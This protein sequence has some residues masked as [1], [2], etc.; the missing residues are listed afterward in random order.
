M[1]TNNYIHRFL[2]NGHWQQ[3]PLSAVTKIVIHHTAAP[4]DQRSNNDRLQQHAD[5]EVHSNDW[6]GLAYH[7]MIMRDGQVYQLNE[8]SDVSYTNGIN[9]DSLAVCLDGYFHPPVNNQPTS[10]QL[11]S[12]Q[13][14]LDNLCNH[15]PEFPASQGDVVGHRE[16][17]RDPTA[18]PG[19]G[20]I[21]YVIN[22]RQK[23]QLLNRVNNPPIIMSNPPIPQLQ[24]KVHAAINE[25]Q[26]SPRYVKQYNN[27][28]RAHGNTDAAAAGREDLVWIR[29]MSNDMQ[30]QADKLVLDLRTQVQLLE[31]FPIHNQVQLMQWCQEKGI[32]CLIDTKSYTS[33]IDG[34]HRLVALGVI[35]E[36]T[37][38]QLNPEAIEQLK[39]AYT[40][41]ID[42]L[43]RQLLLY[44]EKV[45][46][47]G[48]VVSLPNPIVIPTPL[49]TNNPNM[50]NLNITLPK[51]I[52]IPIL[53]KYLNFH[54]VT[55]IVESVK[56]IFILVA[57]AGLLNID[58]VMLLN[59]LVTKDYTYLFKVLNDILIALTS[60]AAVVASNKITDDRKMGLAM[61]MAVTTGDKV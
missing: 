31:N 48:L 34:Y 50:T 10:E 55:L 61:R 19:D 12:L 24:N 46:Q 47:A 25:L 9:Y 33:I 2:T 26:T 32:D 44:K 42:D 5:Y 4:F 22:Y 36:G 28:S 14:L 17:S 23:G 45:R 35:S 57:G 49:P 3:R 20:L 8:F 15:H 56:C 11:N 1:I 58:W 13:E 52:K 43:N 40:A 59:S 54:T 37:A 53:D 60:G 51:I 27:W 21:P 29:E 7:F 6:P 39:Q 18:C 16:H 41:T 38:G 30:E